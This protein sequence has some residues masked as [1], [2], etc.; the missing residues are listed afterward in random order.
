MKSLPWGEEKQCRRYPRVSRPDRRPTGTHPGRLARD[1]LRSRR[2]RDRSAEAGRG[3]RNTGRPASRTDDPVPPGPHPAAEVPAPGPADPAAGRL[4]RR[5]RLIALQSTDRAAAQGP[6][7]APLA[8]GRAVRPGGRS[9]L[10]PAT[11]R[12]R[13]RQRHLPSF[14][15]AELR[16]DRGLRGCPQERDSPPGRED[17]TADQVADRVT[18]MAVHGQGLPH[19]KVS[20]KAPAAALARA[21]RLLR[22]RRNT[23]MR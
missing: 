14:G 18:A 16:P 5:S 12:A 10:E 15:A 1:A 2:W 23:H 22:S 11:R 13:P 21:H 6:P 7:R 3:R 9:R 8:A 19:V 20:G 4:V 17:G